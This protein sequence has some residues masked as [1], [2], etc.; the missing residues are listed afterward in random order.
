MKYF[1][2]FL[3]RLLRDHRPFTVCLLHPWNMEC[4]SKPSNVY[5]TVIVVY[6]ILY[7][8]IENRVNSGYIN[9]IDQIIYRQFV[10]EIHNSRSIAHSHS[11]DALPT[12]QSVCTHHNMYYPACDG[13]SALVNVHDRRVNQ[14]IFSAGARKHEIRNSQHLRSITYLLIEW[15]DIG[16]LTGN[17]L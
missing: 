17:I 5:S 7:W 16:R 8:G 9:N 14:I 11:T 4:Y 15:L 2:I 10:T 6:A 13:A 3:P 1:T 12:R